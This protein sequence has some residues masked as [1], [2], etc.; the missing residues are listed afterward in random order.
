MDITVGIAKVIMV[1]I[2]GDTLE[3]TIASLM[4]TKLSVKII[5]K[6]YLDQLKMAA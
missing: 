3:V 6:L 1:S 4:D 2:T 5:T